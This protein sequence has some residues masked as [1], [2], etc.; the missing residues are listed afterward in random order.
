MDIILIIAILLLI[1]GGVGMAVGFLA[2]VI[3]ILIVIAVIVIIWRLIAGR[4]AV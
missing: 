1:F 2:D 4:T 3:W